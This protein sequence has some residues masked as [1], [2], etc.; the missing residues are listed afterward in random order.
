MFTNPFSA[1]PEFITAGHVQAYVVI[2]FLLVVL[3]TLLDVWHKKSAKWFSI[4]AKDLKQYATRE[5]GAG[6]KVG[7]AMK[8][9]ANEVLASGEFENQKRRMSH[10]LM[11]YGFIFF[12]VSSAVMAFF[13][14]VGAFWSLLWH[15]GALM[16][17]VGGLWFWLFIR[18][19]VFAE[20]NK[21]YK[22]HRADLFIVSL[23][24][25][26]FFALLWSFT[27]S[28]VVLVLFLIASVVLFGGVLWSK[29]AHMFFKPMAAYHKRITRADGSWELLP[30]QTRDDPEQRKRHS[31]SLLVDAP[32]EMG[33]GIKREPPNHY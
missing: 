2:M 20:G 16:I 25:T 14:Q 29:F 13:P 23:L 19:D 26:A 24:A 12:V 3:G 27:H 5:V 33:L 21:W 32:M 9:V 30:T 31:M 10:L 8:V 15:L 28:L 7:I 6:E 4:K 18:V 22:V 11:M 1:L 17:L